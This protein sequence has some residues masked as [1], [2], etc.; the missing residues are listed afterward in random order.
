[1]SHL[2]NHL[3]MNIIRMADGGLQTHKAKTGTMLTHI[4]SLQSYRD[5]NLSIKTSLYMGA[6]A[7]GERSIHLHSIWN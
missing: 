4:N 2:P 1:M 6:V 5:G 3:I 7:C